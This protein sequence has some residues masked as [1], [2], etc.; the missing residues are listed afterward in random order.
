MCI[1]RGKITWEHRESTAVGYSHP[2][3]R[4]SAEPSPPL[5]IQPPG[6]GIKKFVL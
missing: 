3:E 5:I 6:L 2:G 1:H 4:P